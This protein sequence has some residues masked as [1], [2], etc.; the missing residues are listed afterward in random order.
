MRF[1]SLCEGLVHIERS[2]VLHRGVDQSGIQSGR[3]LV[4][5]PL[6]LALLLL[7][8][9]LLLLQL[10][11]LIQKLLNG[12]G[13]LLLQRGELLIELQRSLIEVSLA[14]GELKI[15]SFISK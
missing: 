11:D 15:Y 2:F 4:E 1:K 6:H 9:L 7:R 8:S 10:L 5:F 13:S 3:G 14:L 12:V